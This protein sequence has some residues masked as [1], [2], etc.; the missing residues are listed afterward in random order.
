M[1]FDWLVMGTGSTGTQAG[2]VAGF[3]ALGHDLSVMGVS[4]RQPRDRQVEAVHTLVKLTLE[5][6]EAPTAPVR[7]VLV[8]D[9][10]VGDGYGI[11]AQSTLEA[12]SLTAHCEG[13][14]LDPVYSGKGMAG[15]IGLVRQGFFKPSDNVL[16]LHTGGSAALF[17]YED[18]ITEGAD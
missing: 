4:V 7:K 11:P 6:L 10:Y 8:D 17:A 9:G 13:I 3:H 12:I 16:F 18:L 1:N 5:R 15:L 2:L 14:L